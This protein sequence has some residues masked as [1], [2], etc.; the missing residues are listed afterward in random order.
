MFDVAIRVAALAGPLAYIVACV[1]W[2]RRSR[3]HRAP[4]AAPQEDEPEIAGAEHPAVVV[5][6]VE[7]PDAA[8][9]S[10]RRERTLARCALAALVSLTGRGALRWT[11]GDVAPRGAKDAPEGL[12][13]WGL[14]RAGSTASLG[15]LDR[16]ALDALIPEGTGAS[17]VELLNALR[18]RD[19]RFERRLAAFGEALDRELAARGLVGEP[20]APLLA[21]R[22]WP[23]S[24]ALAW[25]A[26]DIVL[27]V[28][29]MGTSG[30]ES[31]VFSVL[32]VGV[33]SA[34]ASLRTSGPLTS[35]GAAV[36]GAA[37]AVRD[38]LAAD[39]LSPARCRDAGLRAR[40]ASAPRWA[41]D[42]RAWEL[43]LTLAVCTSDL[44]NEDEGQDF[45][46][47]ADAVAAL[48]RSAP[49]EVRRGRGFRELAR[50]FD[51]DGA[52][53]P[54]DRAASPAVAVIDPFW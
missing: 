5:A 40:P 3:G 20:P 38:T 35:R 54:E 19:P 46:R 25:L 30:P 15:A 26:V 36:A 53:A 4:E 44:D 43:A 33:I 16:A 14:E 32:A 45:T 50:W 29:V 41:T 12:A 48:A 6:L 22:R 11:Y 2:G 34:W 27:L 28:T 37:L 23:F 8:G 24:A 17:L 51:L 39:A 49:A 9:F 42:V 47:A 13:G 10:D 7:S 18:G 21:L 31:L 52:T 1:V